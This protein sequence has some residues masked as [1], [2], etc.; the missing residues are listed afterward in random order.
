MLRLSR[1]ADYGVLLL[2]HLARAPEALVRTH[3][4]ALATGV[5]APMA[6]KILQSLQQHG[7]VQS[8]RGARGGYRLARAPE[9]ITV[10]EVVAAL[11]GGVALTDCLVDASRCEQ[12]AVC[13]T[14]HAWRRI[15]RAIERAL[16]D[17][18]LAD[19]ADPG[20][21]PELRLARGREAA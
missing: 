20:F 8:V 11:E 17:I 2:A 19:M 14:S 12:S 9:D 7:I 15:S 21:A 16:E 18:T 10:G 13:A 6:S 5:P 1:M 4:A 3:E